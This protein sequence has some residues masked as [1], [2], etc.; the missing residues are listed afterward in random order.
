[1]NTPAIP[2]EG[3]EGMAL[4]Q[5]DIAIWE[6]IFDQ[7]GN[8]VGTRLLF[9]SDALPKDDGGEVAVTGQGRNGKGATCGHGADSWT[10]LPKTYTGAEYMFESPAV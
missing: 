3:R 4:D 7:N 8:D 5:S 1:V 2:G 6:I 10:N 9:C